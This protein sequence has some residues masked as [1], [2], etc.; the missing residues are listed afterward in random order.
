MVDDFNGIKTISHSMLID[1]TFS[2]S[3]IKIKLYNVT[4]TSFHKINHN[5][6]IKFDVNHK[7]IF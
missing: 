6:N 3:F 5:L 1:H 7:L 4:I 2:I